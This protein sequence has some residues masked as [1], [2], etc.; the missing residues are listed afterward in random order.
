MCMCAHGFTACVQE[1]PM[2]REK[3]RKNKEERGGGE[4]RG[5]GKNIARN[6]TKAARKG[7]RKGRYWE[8]T[9]WFFVFFF[10][11]GCLGFVLISV[12]CSFAAL[13]AS[14]WPLQSCGVLRKSVCVCLLCALRRACVGACVGVKKQKLT[15]KKRICVKKYNNLPPS[16]LSSSQ[17]Q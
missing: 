9:G 11:L 16:L 15:G 6:D 17:P 10:I 4:R 13:A 3:K 12:R 8:R 1:F 14:D 7:V 5:S 2:L